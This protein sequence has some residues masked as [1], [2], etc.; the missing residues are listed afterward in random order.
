M[1]RPDDSSLNPEDRRFVE[2]RAKRLLDR[3]DAWGRFPTQVDDI[4][5]A[6]ELKVAAVSVFDP[7]SLLSFL[8]EKGSHTAHILKAAVAKILGVYDGDERTVHIDPGVVATKQTFLKLHEAGHHELPAHRKMFRFFQDC[9]KT[10]HPDIAD[11]FER[12]ANNFARFVLFQGS[13]FGEMAADEKLG[14][15]SPIKL[16]EHFGASIYASVREFTR[17]SRHACLAYALEPMEYVPIDGYRA[18]IRRIEA[19]PSFSLR[20]GLPTGS[21]IT[22]RDALGPLLPIGRKMT[23]PTAFAM[24]DRNGESQEMIG[25][26]FSTKYNIFILIYAVAS[27]ARPAIIGRPAAPASTWPRQPGLG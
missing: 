20:F 2:D 26:A 18:V 10:L 21:V 6:A 17:T 14:I 23:K 27:L 16:A 8:K 13:T 12:E 25:E 5:A 9:E 19:S 22:Q 1:T 24:S 4:M 11:Q 3:A 7:A 15:R